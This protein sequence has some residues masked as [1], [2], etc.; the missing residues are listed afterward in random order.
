MLQHLA[1]S[2][3]AL[4]VKLKLSSFS[5]CVCVCVCVCVWTLSRVRL[6]LT[7]W[8]VAARFCPWDSPSK[9]TR[10]G[11]HFLIQGIFLTHGSNP[12]LPYSR[13]ILYHRTAS[14]A[15]FS[16]SRKISSVMLQPITLL[17]HL[18][19]KNLSRLSSFKSKSSAVS[20]LQTKYQSL[21]HKSATW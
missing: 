4:R 14:E 13:Q 17:M 9:N 5:V 16:T 11:C 3:I 2:L 8:T 18:I 1:H 21:F 19:S 6:F 10:V 7:P 15:M 12:S 20:I